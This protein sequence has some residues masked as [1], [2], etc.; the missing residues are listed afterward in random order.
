MLDPKPIVDAFNATVAPLEAELAAA[1]TG[2]EPLKQEAVGL[3]A[4]VLEQ[5]TKVTALTE[6]LRVVTA[7]RDRAWKRGEA[8]KVDIT[9]LGN[10]VEALKKRLA[11]L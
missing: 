2:L 7:E 5:T 6:S 10:E 9:E 3:R 11:S 4:A 8:F 1:K